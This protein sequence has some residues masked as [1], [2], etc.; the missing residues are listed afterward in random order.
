MSNFS[1]FCLPAIGGG[2]ELSHGGDPQE[3][4]ETKKMDSSKNEKSESDT[5]AEKTTKESLNFFVRQLQ[6]EAQRSY[7]AAQALLKEIEADSPDD[8]WGWQS[9]QD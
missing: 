1:I 3:H 4:K 2:G 9:E 8:D 6:K 5:S 7:F